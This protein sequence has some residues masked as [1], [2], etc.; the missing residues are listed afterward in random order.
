[1]T[2]T[3]RLRSEFG[4][5]AAI[6]SAK[7][8]EILFIHGVGLRA[9]AWN[10]QID[11]MSK[12]AATTAVDLPG[13]GDSPGLTG[14]VTLAEYTDAVAKAMDEPV[15]VVGHSM[16]A[17]IALDLAIRYPALIRAVVAL[18]TVFERSP[19]ASAAVRARAAELVGRTPTSPQATLARWF[20][21]APSDKRTACEQWLNSVDPKGYQLAYHVFAHSD[22]PDP[23]DV[24]RIMCPAVFMTGGEEPNSTPAM[25]K[26][27]AQLAPNGS[28]EIV[29]GAA[30]MLP[31]T[32]PDRVNATLLRLMRKVQR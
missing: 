31:M 27:L 26:R 22:G 1:M 6:R 23:A 14:S 24:Q 25:S 17:L 30:H 2:W 13:H 20:G 5:L 28:A 4:S 32:H 10:A 21:G 7:T 3:T 8:T 16:G 29:D 12:V 9:E 18:N 15:V 11:T 19:S